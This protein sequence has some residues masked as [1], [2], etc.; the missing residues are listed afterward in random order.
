MNSLSR[1]AFDQLVRRIEDGT[2]HSPRLLAA[3]CIG[4][5]LAGLL[6][7]MLWVFFLPLC[8][9][10]LLAGAF[11]VPMMEGGWLLA[12]AGAFL[13]VIGV[14]HAVRVLWTRSEPP[15]GL[16]VTQQ[17][18]PELFADIETMRR[19]LG[20]R[21][22]DRV[23]LTPELNASVR[24]EPKFGVV[25]PRAHLLCLGLPL[26]H[27]MSRDE[28]RSVIAHELGHLSARHGRFGAM[29]YR[30]RRSWVALYENME[31]A[32][33][34]EQARKKKIL[35]RIVQWYWPRFH[36]RI[37]VLSRSNEYHADREAARLT[38]ASTFIS[39]LS[40]LDLASRLLAE[41][42]WQPL[43]ITACEHAEPPDGAMQSIAEALARP[44]PVE[45]LDTWMFQ[46][47]RVLT[48]NDDTHP[49]LADRAKALAQPLDK[50]VRQI[51]TGDS[52]AHAYLGA[53][54]GVW[55]PKLDELWKKDLQEGW[56]K[57]HK[58]A[59]AVRHQLDRISQRG[60][61]DKEDLWT[62]ACATLDTRGADEAAPLFARILEIDPRHAGARFNLACHDLNEMREKGVAEIE[63]AMRLSPG[64]SL[65]GCA[66]LRLYYLRSGQMEKVR[67]VERRMDA[68]EH[69]EGSDQKLLLKYAPGTVFEHGLSSEQ[70]AALLQAL[71]KQRPIRQAW[72]ARR[73]AQAGET[74]DTFLLCI[75]TGRGRWRLF[76]TDRERGIARVLMHEIH[77]PGRAMIFAPSLDRRSLASEVRRVPGSK[78]HQA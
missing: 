63:E 52:A 10:G 23:Y 59:L 25:G 2:R 12:L 54:I 51:N 17:D 74:Q 21:R 67:E 56:S 40:R 27:C 15:D 35:S 28:F 32:S 8:G 33:G 3:S 55:A 78:I 72:L 73:A 31:N 29:L 39:A 68:H 53:Q 18:L 45:L 26:M 77:L 19:E 76:G 38:S 22:F 50:P 34:N 66:A 60:S 16:L 48:T 46:A 65:D 30:L 71:E 41:T 5:M 13:L 4:W 37:F 7:L 42:F 58:R 69:R 47:R 11:F 70:L 6:F 24:E 20:A 9:L 62:I 1:E 44:Q 49:C 57:R 43:Q 14:V 75:S 36:A 61:T 64:A